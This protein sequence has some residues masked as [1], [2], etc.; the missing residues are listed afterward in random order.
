MLGDVQQR[1]T[2]RV[3]R[4]EAFN[5]RMRLYPDLHGML[6]IV[7]C[8]EMLRALAR[9]KSQVSHCIRLVLGPFGNPCAGHI[10]V[11]ALAILV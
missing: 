3:E 5:V 1:K 11:L 8:V 7:R 9:K 4:P 6:E 2:V 10:N